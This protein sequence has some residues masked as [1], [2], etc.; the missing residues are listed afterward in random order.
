MES[1]IRNIIKNPDIVDLILI[2]S[3][4]EITSKPCLSYNIKGLVHLIPL[5]IFDPQLMSIQSPTKC[6]LLF[7]KNGQLQFPQISLEG[8]VM[9]DDSTTIWE[10]M[11]KAWLLKYPDLSELFDVKELFLPQQNRRVMLSFKPSCIKAWKTIDVEPNIIEME[12]VK[13]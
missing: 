10:E 11:K 4:D 8:E 2:S 6:S 12:I 7:L 9:K 1:W 13:S 5:S 3:K